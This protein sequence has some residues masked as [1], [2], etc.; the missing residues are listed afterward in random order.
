VRKSA[1][2]MGK[3]A[4]NAAAKGLRDLAE[5]NETIAVI[6]ATGASQL[7]TLDALSSIPD[8]PWNSVV[9]FHMD[10][11]PGISNQHSALF[12]RYLRHR[13]TK[14]RLVLQKQRNLQINCANIP[15]QLEDICLRGLKAAVLERM[16]ASPGVPKSVPKR[17]RLGANP[18]LLST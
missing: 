3:A 13:L 15:P 12:H 11:Y 1:E 16:K 5:R 4:A 2:D 7:A 17:T 9:G 8:V 10:E 18:G 6:Y 14:I